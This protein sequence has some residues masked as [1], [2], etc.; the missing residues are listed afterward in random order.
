[1]PEQTVLQTLLDKFNMMMMSSGDGDD[2]EGGE[3]DYRL[4]RHQHQQQMM[5][6]IMLKDACIV[7][8][9]P[10]VAASTKSPPPC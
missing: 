10:R 8:V 9:L 2:K 7:S 1:M 5:V 4:S 6:V 3:G